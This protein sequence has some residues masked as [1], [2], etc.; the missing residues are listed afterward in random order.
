[1]AE[2]FGLSELVG[3]PPRQIPLGTRAGNSIPNLQGMPPPAG[4]VLYFHDT[5]A[6]HS[7]WH[8]RAGCDGLYNCAGHVWADRR[9]GIHEGDD[10]IRILNEDGYRRTSSPK[11][12]D[13]VLYYTQEDGYLHVAKIVE[14][15]I[16]ISQRV[17]WVLS[18][19]GHTY[20]EFYH[21][22]DDPWL[23]DAH[24]VR[25]ECWTNCFTDNLKKA[26]FL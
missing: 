21:F 5:V 4:Q 3:T 9:T 26:A 17:A 19:W 16:R 22:V 15:K 20:G 12:D 25:V 8:L 13:I 24:R 7:N 2:M 18:K 6:A 14:F 23:P 1:M 11:L 10:W